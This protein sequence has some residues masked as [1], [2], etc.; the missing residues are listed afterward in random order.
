M[1]CS[2]APAPSRFD[3]FGVIE[4]MLFLDFLH[5]HMFLGSL[6]FSDL[7][8]FFRSEQQTPTQRM[9]QILKGEFLGSPS[10]SQIS[11]ASP[12]KMMK[13]G[14]EIAPTGSCEYRIY[15]AGQK[16]RDFIAFQT[17]MYI[18]DYIYLSSYMQRRVYIYKYKYIFIYISSN[19][20]I[21][22]PQKLETSNWNPPLHFQPT[23]QPRSPKVFQPSFHE[24]MNGQSWD[25]G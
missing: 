1:I 12:S 5:Q 7:P 15:F 2:L 13:W 16:K 3:Q 20:Y 19:I 24:A 22:T 8:S 6:F 10:S 17:R 23:N 25:V 21:H 9:G 11:K 4:V 18:Y 14:R